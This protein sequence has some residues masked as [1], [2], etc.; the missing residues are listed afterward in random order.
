MDP[1][2]KAKPEEHAVSEPEAVDHETP[3]LAPSGTCYHQRDKRQR[4]YTIKDQY[5]RRYGFSIVE[6]PIKGDC[7]AYEDYSRED[8]P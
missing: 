3:P 8:R 4:H 5:T 7:A 6:I 1:S 2:S